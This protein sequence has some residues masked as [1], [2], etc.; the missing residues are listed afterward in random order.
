MT[1]D[2]VCQLYRD[3]C[4]KRGKEVSDEAAR[5]AVLGFIENEE[6]EEVNDRPRI[7]LVAG[8]FRPEVTAS[9]IWLRKF[10]VDISCVKLS[11][12]KMGNGEIAFESNIVIPLPEARDF[13]IEMERRGT[14]SLR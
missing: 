1:L 9:V 6:F 11:P 7:I 12:Y 3:F 4:G 5:E 13:I 2:Q 8:Q 10:G 14:R